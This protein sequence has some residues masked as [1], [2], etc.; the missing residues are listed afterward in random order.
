MHIPTY[1]YAHMYTSQV[2]LKQ[3]EARQRQRRVMAEMLTM[4]DGHSA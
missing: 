4:G 2:Q 3:E 1:A